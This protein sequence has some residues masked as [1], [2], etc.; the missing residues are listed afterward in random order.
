MYCFPTYTPEG[1][2]CAA[3]AP[4]GAA[5]VLRQ[6]VVG[7]GAPCRRTA[8]RALRSA[9]R[10]QNREL[11]PRPSPICAITEPISQALSRYRP[12]TDGM[13]ERLRRVLEEELRRLGGLSKLAAYCGPL[14]VKVP[15]RDRAESPL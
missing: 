4:G 2:G 6:A 14:T 10:L 12:Q 11:P 13:P 15:A 3:A 7:L 9:G 1:G 5:A 8:D